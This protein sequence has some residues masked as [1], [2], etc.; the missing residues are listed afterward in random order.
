[1]KPF[2][3]QGTRNFGDHMNSWLW[4]RLIP[5]LL[6]QGDDVRLIGIGSLLKDS[7]AALP[8]EKVI[9]GTGSGYGPI[10]SPQEY[11]TWKFYFVRGPL[12]A[13]AFDLDRKLGLIDG[14]WLISQIQELSIPSTAKAGTLFIPHWTTSES[15]NWQPVC[16]ESGIEYLDPCMPSLEVLRR[17]NNSELV[18]TESLHGAIIAD[19]YRTPWIPTRLSNTYLEF[20][21]FDWFQ[22]ICVSPDIKTLP[23]SDIFD[24]ISLRQRASAKSSVAETHIPP[25]SERTLHHPGL[26]YRSTISAKRLLRA[27]RS[28]CF[29]SLKPVRRA[30]SMA[31]VGRPTFVEAMRCLKEIQNSSPTLSKAETHSEKIDSL[32]TAIERL[33]H[34]YK[35]K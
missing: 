3:W 13:K 5:Q 1:M 15:S 6:S 9:F 7:L 30:V 23:P 20:K 24:S 10:P 35:S 12:T 18:I 31:S 8:G 27:T 21:W 19:Y 16:Q 34:D 17:I 33:R 4:P 26:L 22:S 29:A 2:Y 25:K 14:A 32:A 11:S 28:A